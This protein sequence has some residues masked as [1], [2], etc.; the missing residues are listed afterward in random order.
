M[1]IAG[2]E[3]ICPG[4]VGLFTGEPFSYHKYLDVKGVGEGVT[5]YGAEAVVGW[6]R[7]V[8]ASHAD[9]ATKRLLDKLLRDRLSVGEAVVRTVAE[10]GPDPRYGA[11]LRVLVSE[12]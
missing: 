6:S 3:V 9:T 5:T 4:P 12:G 10:V 1:E 8:S 7:A 11:E 2:G